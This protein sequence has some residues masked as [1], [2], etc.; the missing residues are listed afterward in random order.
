MD[1][2]GDLFSL[3]DYVRTYV[4]HR[5]DK[6]GGGC[7]KQQLFPTPQ[8]NITIICIIFFPCKSDGWVEQA[9][10]SPTKKKKKEQGH[11]NSSFA[12][13]F[14]H[15]VGSVFLLWLVLVLYRSIS[16]QQL[17]TRMYFWFH[18]DMRNARCFLHQLQYCFVVILSPHLCLMP[19]SILVLGP[20]CIASFVEDKGTSIVYFLQLIY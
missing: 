4:G 8:P 6:G 20:M 16:L 12:C 9:T 18:I 19:F 10:T 17:N 1:K 14:V 7:T 15:L 2:F 3:L 5:S 13:F 11:I